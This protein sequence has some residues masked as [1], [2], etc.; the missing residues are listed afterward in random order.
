MMRSTTARVP[1]R[2]LISSLAGTTAWRDRRNSDRSVVFGAT[3]FGNVI[4]RRCEPGRAIGD[5]LPGVSGIGFGSCCRKL[6]KRDS[7]YRLGVD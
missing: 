7:Y 2:G 4:P 6:R 5:S 3:A 1:S